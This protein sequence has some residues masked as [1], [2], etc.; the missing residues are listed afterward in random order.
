MNTF[1][2]YPPGMEQRV[3]EVNDCIEA[4]IDEQNVRIVGVNAY[5]PV[6]I[7]PLVVPRDATGTANR[8][9]NWVST[10]SDIHE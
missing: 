5:L 6:A 3:A 1:Y 7:T 10:D 2:I 8:P 4:I 9:K